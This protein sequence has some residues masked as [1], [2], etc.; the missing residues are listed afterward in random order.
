MAVRRRRR[1]YH[2]KEDIVERPFSVAGDRAELEPQVSDQMYPGRLHPHCVDGLLCDQHEKLTVT[3]HD[4]FPKTA[5]RAK[6][7][8]A[9]DGCT[10]SG[11]T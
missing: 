5:E 10:T 8:A 6:D 9:S 3:G 11:G 2:L 4:L 7:S 1:V